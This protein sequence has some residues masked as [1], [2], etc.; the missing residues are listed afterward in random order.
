MNERESAGK[1]LSDG[2]LKSIIFAKMPV[3]TATSLRQELTNEKVKS[4]WT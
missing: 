4:W 3:D 1:H 2:E